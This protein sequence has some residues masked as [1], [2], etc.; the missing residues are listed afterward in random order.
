M[1]LISTLLSGS[2]VMALLPAPHPAPS[3]SPTEKPLREIGHVRVTTP[4]CKAIL[5]RATTAINI[6]VEDDLKLANAVTWLRKADLD[7]SQLAKYKSTN[8]FRRQYVSLR[9]LAVEGESVMGEFRKQ[10]KAAP[11]DEQRAALDKF[12]DALAGA[13]HRQKKL[14]EDLGRYLAFLDTHDPL[15]NDERAEIETQII[16]NQSNPLVPHDPFGDWNM[17]PP[18]LSMTAHDAAD[19]VVVRAAKIDE[20]E[21]DAATRIDPAFEKC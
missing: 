12:A 13:I 21:A 8:E 10:A 7:S 19:E 18:T 17:V 15:T 2:L 20:D 3:P 11:T 14:A 16:A 4:F 5:E 9:A 6:A 1:N